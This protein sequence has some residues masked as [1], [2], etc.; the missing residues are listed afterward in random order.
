MKEEG[1]GGGAHEKQKEIRLVERER[2]ESEIRRKEEGGFDK[3][4][5]LNIWQLVV[6]FSFSFSIFLL[7][8]DGKVLLSCV[9]DCWTSLVRVCSNVHSHSVLSDSV[10][11]TASRLMWK[12]SHVQWLSMGNLGMGRVSW[13]VKIGRPCVK[14]IFS[15]DTLNLG[16]VSTLEH[17]S[18]SGRI[19]WKNSLDRSLAYQNQYQTWNST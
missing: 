4:G 2:K 5:C 1:W 10:M 11:L 16:H 12:T 13:V 6:S 14:W 18:K 19:Q 9:C 7:E 8:A 15:L 3:K 17:V